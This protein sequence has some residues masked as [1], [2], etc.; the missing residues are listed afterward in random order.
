MKKAFSK[1]TKG[2]TLAE[3]LIALALI[4][5]IAVF[6]VPKVLNAQGNKEY[7]AKA[8]SAAA[9]LAAA[10][11][12]Y[13][14]DYGTNNNITG[15][16][17]GAYLNYV[18]IQTSNEEIDDHFSASNTKDCDSNDYCYVLPSGGVIRTATTESFGDVNSTTSA[19]RFYFDPDGKVTTDGSAGSPGKS[20]R[21]HLYVNGNVLD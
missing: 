4:G 15:T 9:S 7:I 19:I 21:F 12:N 20:V 5:V 11:S 18:K 13:R 8:K 14:L 10:Y 16:H 1:S 17:I 6:T 2:F 3:L